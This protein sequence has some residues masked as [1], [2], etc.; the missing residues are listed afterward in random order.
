MARAGTTEVIWR[1]PAV[2]TRSDLNVEPFGASMRYLTILFS[3]IFV[4]GGALECRAE[5]VSV[6]S[7]EDCVKEASRNNPNLA[8]AVESVYQAR[9]AKAITVSGF[10]SQ[11]KTCEPIPLARIASPVPHQP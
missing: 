2:K 8:V 7:W 1:V 11:I 9:A 4:M 3:L 10:T 6:L 5:D